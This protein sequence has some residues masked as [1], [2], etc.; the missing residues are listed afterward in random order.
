[1]QIKQKLLSTIAVLTIILTPVVAAAPAYAATSTTTSQPNFLQG[2]VGFLAQKFGLDQTQLQN[3]VN[4]YKSQQQQT[5]QQN[6]QNREKT[7]LDS[8]VAKGTI[9]STQE[10][11]ILDELAKLK[12][13]YPPSSFKGLT[14]D[15]RKQKFNQEQAEIQA[16]SRSTGIDAKYLHPGW[17]MRL[18]MFN[19][20]DD[21]AA[22]STGSGS[23]TP[24]VT[25]T[26]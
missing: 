6:M 25:P 11:Q 15:Q 4:D 12:S 2:L 7:H 24:T 14:A 10:Q 19:R 21:A 17:G 3:A 22:P 1:M 9:T 18:H 16:W 13:E 20:W 8:L 26:P 5:R 23:V